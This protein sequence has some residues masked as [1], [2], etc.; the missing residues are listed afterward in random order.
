VFRGGMQVPCQVTMGA[1]TVCTSFR[2][3]RKWPKAGR[4][5]TS[6]RNKVAAANEAE[7]PCQKF[8]GEKVN[9]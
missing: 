8:T 1:E 7:E 3:Q 9:P 5:G 4:R 6:V 2:R